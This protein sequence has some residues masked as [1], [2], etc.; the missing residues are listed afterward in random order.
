MPRPAPEPSFP[1]GAGN[2]NLGVSTSV[3][4]NEISLLTTACQ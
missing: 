4:I 1:L 2:P 3:G